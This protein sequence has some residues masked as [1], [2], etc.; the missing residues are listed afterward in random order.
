MNNFKKM[1]DDIKRSG[2][3]RMKICIQCDKFKKMTKQCENC[4][5]FMP[6]KVLVPSMHCPENKW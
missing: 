6:A 3:E 5:C 2:V 4:G 1:V